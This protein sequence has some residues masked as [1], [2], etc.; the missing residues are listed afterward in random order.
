LARGG[1]APHVTFTADGTNWKL[2]RYAA[3]AVVSEEDLLDD[4]PVRV[5]L[6][7]GEQ[8]GAAA[9]RV[10]GD[11][12]YSLLLAN[13]TLAD[14][15]ALFATGHANLGTGGGS[16]LD[17]TSLG[18]GMAAIA[19]QVQRDVQERAIHVNGEGRFLVVPPQ[20]AATA[21]SIVRNVTLGDGHDL[22][23][24]VESRL[25]A[26]GVTDPD[27]GQTFAGTATNWLLCAKETATPSIVIGAL[28]G[29]MEPRLTRFDLGQG[30]FGMGLAVNLDVAAAAVDHRGLYWSAG[31]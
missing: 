30:E 9:R 21:R 26:A 27:S 23:V 31:A 8:L 16:A 12:V 29:R 11:L 10:V 1:N 28:D 7:L 5:L 15:T 6:T 14:G 19:A 2:S 20:L 18:A 25:G 4:A 3:Q 22:Q 24:R 13:P 17:A